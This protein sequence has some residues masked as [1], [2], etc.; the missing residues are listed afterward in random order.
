MRRPKLRLRLGTRTWHGIGDERPHLHTRD[1][2]DEPR[3]LRLTDEDIEQ[4][5]TRP[6]VLRLHTSRHDLNPNSGVD[7]P[8]D[9]A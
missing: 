5:R 3:F 2:D 1:P 9:A 4:A 7:H 6:H 8:D